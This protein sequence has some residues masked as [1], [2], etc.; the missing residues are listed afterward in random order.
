MTGRK[1]VDPIA[2]LR[3]MLVVLDNRRNL[4]QR[5][6]VDAARKMASDAIAVL[7]EPDPLKQRI[8]FVLLAIQQSTEVKVFTR[9]DREFRRARIVDPDLYHWAIDQVH[10]LA[11]TA[12]TA[13]ES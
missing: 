4:P 7:Q 13:D 1:K 5:E 8:A 2:H 9:G 3:G 11:G 10:Q 12:T 6:I